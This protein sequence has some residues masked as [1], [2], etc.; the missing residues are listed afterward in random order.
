MLSSSVPDLIEERVDTAVIV[1][2][3]DRLRVQVEPRSVLLL[4]NAP[5]H[6]SNA[7]RA[8]IPTWVSRGVMVQ[9]VLSSVELITRSPFRRPKICKIIGAE[10]KP[11]DQLLEYGGRKE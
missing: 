5:M 10:Q 9:Y 1:E 11:L 4:D 6:R 7:F 8:Q 2:C 3:F